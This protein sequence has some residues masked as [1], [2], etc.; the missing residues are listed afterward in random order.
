M[1][2]KDIQK[3]ETPVSSENE[4]DN[5]KAAFDRFLFGETIESR[6]EEYIDPRFVVNF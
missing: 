2:N 6:G 4:K 3:I 5:L 1:K